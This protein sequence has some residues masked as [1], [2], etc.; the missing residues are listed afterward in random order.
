[1][2]NCDRLFPADLRQARRPQQAAAK[3]K[4]KFVELVRSTAKVKMSAELELKLRAIYYDR[5]EPEQVEP[6]IRGIYNGDWSVERELELEDIEFL[7]K[8]APRLFPD[9]PTTITG[10][11]V[12]KAVWDLQDSLI[13]ERQGVVDKLFVALTNSL[14]PDREPAE[15]KELAAQV[16]KLFERERFATKK[17]LEE[18][19]KLAADASQHFPA[20]FHSAITNVAAIKASFRSS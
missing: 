15:V 10:P 14:Y 18:L 20:E 16:G 12:R 8:N 5:I 7:I 17:E 3:I 2:R 1:M 4:E 19:K 9:D 6:I 11:G 13:A